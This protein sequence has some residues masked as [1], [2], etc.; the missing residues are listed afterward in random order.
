MSLNRRHYSE[1]GASA[2][3]HMDISLS[4]GGVDPILAKQLNL[5]L[6]LHQYSQELLHLY[7]ESQNWA[8]ISQVAQTLVSSSARIRELKQRL[9]DLQDGLPLQL[10][11]LEKISESEARLS[12]S[13][14]PPVATLRSDKE[15]QPTLETPF[16]SL[17]TKVNNN[18]HHLAVL[19]ECNSEKLP[20]SDTESENKKL[21]HLESD[22]ASRQHLEVSDHDIYAGTGSGTVVTA[23]EQPEPIITVNLQQKSEFL[24][25]VNA[26]EDQTEGVKEFEGVNAVNDIDKIVGKMESLAFDLNEQYDHMQSSEPPLLTENVHMETMETMGKGAVKSLN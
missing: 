14:E 23:A 19:P 24:T 16:D 20:N 8:A 15:D 10:P 2:R 3:Y 18:N 26:Q 11:Y 4:G 7:K 17:S 12:L 9:R 1:S 13:P 21:H 22:P 25:P 5:E 6:K